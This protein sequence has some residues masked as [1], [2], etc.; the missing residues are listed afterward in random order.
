[1]ASFAQVDENN[2][3]QNIILIDDSCLDNNGEFPESEESGREFIRNLNI[4]GENSRWYQASY[5]GKFRKQYPFKDFI[6]VEE[7]DMFVRP[8]P[9]PSWS[10]ENDGEWYAPQP[11]PKDGKV[12]IWSESEQ[13]WILSPIQPKK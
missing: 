12:Y 4:G 3:V 10:L 2:V 13:Q 7:L 1:M 6:Y 11:I 5:T 9:Y 8:K